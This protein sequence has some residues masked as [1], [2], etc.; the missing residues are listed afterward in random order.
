VHNAACHDDAEHNKQ[1]HWYN[2][3]CLDQGLPALVPAA[4]G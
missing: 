4:A 2:E 3:G 1:Q